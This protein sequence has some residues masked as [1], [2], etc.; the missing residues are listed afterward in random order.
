[1]MMSVSTPFQE[2]LVTGIW[3]TWDALVIDLGKICSLE[4]Q[5][6]RIHPMVQG[7][8]SEE[9]SSLSSALH[10]RNND[11]RGGEGSQLL[12]PSAEGCSFP[13]FWRG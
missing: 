10:V 5:G 7:E 11:E 9:T 2:I 13:L 12:D 4:C 3:M 6:D 1:M 8:K